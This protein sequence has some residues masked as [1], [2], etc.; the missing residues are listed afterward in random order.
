MAF[1]FYPQ[2]LFSFR[3]VKKW[4]FFT[5]IQWK[6]NFSLH[7]ENNAPFPS[8]IQKKLPLFTSVKSTPFFTYLPMKLPIFYNW[9]RML[10]FR[11]YPKEITTISVLELVGVNF[12]SLAN[13]SA[14]NNS[15]ECFYNMPNG[16]RRI[17]C[18]QMR[19]SCFEWG[20]KVPKQQ[21]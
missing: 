1:P 2:K 17:T 3:S 10:L 4:C 19:P 20:S 9:K 5:S 16:V 6:Y 15:L 13:N 14:F 21:T 12:E 7:L 8:L 11:I 18:M